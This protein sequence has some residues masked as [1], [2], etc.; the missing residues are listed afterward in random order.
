M[1]GDALGAGGHEALNRDHGQIERDVEV[2]QGAT[3]VC[4]DLR[5]SRVL[6]ECSLRY[7]A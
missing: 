5:W 3:H 6:S 4:S 2:F 7:I 1:E